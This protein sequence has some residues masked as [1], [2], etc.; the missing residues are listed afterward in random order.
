MT[1]IEQ[2]KKELIYNQN[3]PLFAPFDDG[4]M[5]ERR[6]GL[7]YAEIID[8]GHDCLNIIFDDGE[9]M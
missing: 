4:E 9:I 1:I 2:Y 5:G 8:N 3:H 7:F 6:P